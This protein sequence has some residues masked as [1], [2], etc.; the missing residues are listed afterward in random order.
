MKR[1]T[2]YLSTAFTLSIL[3]A[4][5]QAA[6]DTIDVTFTSPIIVG[7]TDRATG[8]VENVS[9]EAKRLG[10]SSIRLLGEVK[11][12]Q[13]QGEN[14]MQVRWTDVSVDNAA[15]ES[16]SG[17]L[18]RPLESRFRT[19]A[20]AVRPG[21]TVKARGDVSQLNETL[22]N[23]LTA[24]DGQEGAGKE[25][26][27]RTAST[28]GKQAEGKE[29]DRI[30]R[31]S[32]G[33]GGFGSGGYGNDPDNYYA[34]AQLTP[35]NEACAPLV[36][37][38]AGTVTPQTKR[39]VMDPDGNVIA[40]GG[41]VPSG[42][43]AS[44]QTDYQSCPV[45]IDHEQMRAYRTY[46]KFA[47]VDGKSMEVQGC[48]VDF[49]QEIERKRDYA[50]CTVMIPE[51]QAGKPVYPSYRW[52][53]M[54]R[55]KGKEFLISDCVRDTDVEYQLESIT[56]SC[57]DYVNTR[58]DGRIY[59]QE[60][61]VYR[62]HN[63]VEHLA[64]NCRR[65]ENHPGFAVIETHEGCDS[66]ELKNAA[67]KILIRPKTRLVYYDADGV[68]RQARACEP[69]AET[70]EV[71]YRVT[72]WKHGNGYSELMAEQIYT[73]DGIEWYWKGSS[74]SVFA[75]VNHDYT[76][77]G[78]SAAVEDLDAHV[79]KQT[80]RALLDVRSETFDPVR[81]QLNIDENGFVQAK[82]CSDA[83]FASTPHILVGWSD[84]RVT[85]SRLVKEEIGRLELG[86]S[87]SVTW[88]NDT[89]HPFKLE[90]HTSDDDWGRITKVIFDPSPIVAK[91]S[92]SLTIPN[93][94]LKVSDLPSGI[95]VSGVKKCQSVG[96]GYSCSNRGH[97]ADHPWRLNN[98]SRDVL[99]DGEFGA[100]CTTYKGSIS[101]AMDADFV[102]TFSLPACGKSVQQDGCAMVHSF[103]NKLNHK[104]EWQRSTMSVDTGL[105]FTW[106]NP[107]S[108]WKMDKGCVA[109][110]NP[111]PG[112]STLI[113]SG[114]S[115]TRERV[116]LWKKPIIAQNGS[117]TGWEQ[118]E[119]LGMVDRQ[120]G[121]LVN[122]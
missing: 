69:S 2:L 98:A 48:T 105:P 28:D 75:R 119:D 47:L 50:A 33:G 63:G 52:V 78:C 38:A 55:D 60:K 18:E 41:C 114:Y 5:I 3:A 54:D 93:R 64:V 19:Q 118:Y 68:Q 32:T 51:M 112:D 90:Y 42:T 77:A 27:P 76:T 56:A 53:G 110:E 92:H 44:I 84:W 57:P 67:G 59:P 58:Q 71:R 1:K 113:C 73:F 29:T 17:T 31:K 21:N 65:V 14:R 89:T 91:W 104:I 61:L 82:G 74:P 108:P 35:A 34:A 111:A 25:S 107:E 117:I 12:E 43:A 121:Y 36:D 94:Q 109:R 116:R 96:G 97:T 16:V 87:C 88:S 9:P 23:I 81:D 13:Q 120:V 39:V 10:V 8:R 7:E 80:S 103:S 95:Q 70:A 15:G 85:A 26:A 101:K 115:Q 83:Q 22:Q 11:A 66:A 106:A 46:R 72:G 40:D 79:T 20:P 102:F 100:V 4:S 45:H 86:D 99:S 24:K 30:S 49:E 122:E 6:S 62:D 37:K